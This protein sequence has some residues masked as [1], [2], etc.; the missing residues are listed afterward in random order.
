MK[1]KNSYSNLQDR[2]SFSIVAAI[3]TETDGTCEDIENINLLLE[4]LY[5]TMF[6]LEEMVEFSDQIGVRPI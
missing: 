5:F 4:K 6:I 1:L 2:T 3:C